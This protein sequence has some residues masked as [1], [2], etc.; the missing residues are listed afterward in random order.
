MV[1]IKALFVDGN[2]EAS[3]PLLRNFLEIST[4]LKFFLKEQAYVEENLVAYQLCY[5]FN[6]NEYIKA[7]EKYSKNE[8]YD[9]I[10][11]EM[12]YKEHK[13]IYALKIK[14]KTYAWYSIVTKKRGR[15][16][17]NLRA[18]SSKLPFN[19][20]T[21]EILYDLI[22]TRSSAYIHGQQALDSAYKNEKF[23]LLSI[24]SLKS[25]SLYLQVIHWVIGDL[26][27]FLHK[28]FSS[29]DIQI[30]EK[31]DAQELNNQGNRLKIL[32]DLDDAL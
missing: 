4:Q 21:Y 19:D 30:M 24:R 2:S 16:I 27:V 23:R 3:I 5:D 31:A 1:G 15:V 29:C 22:Y 32:R 18:L 11:L 28:C 10:D 7:F 26:I 6:Y 8:K 20:K 14:N 17:K 25:S 9:T 13:D 12:R